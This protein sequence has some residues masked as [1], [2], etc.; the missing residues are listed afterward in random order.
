MTCLLNTYAQIS[1]LESLL[2]QLEIE[3]LTPLKSDNPSKNS[4]NTNHESDVRK[5]EMFGRDRKE[6]WFDLCQ[7]SISPDGSLIAIA[8]KQKVVICK[9]K[10][11][12]NNQIK[13]IAS[14]QIIF[15]EPQK[16]GLSN[17]IIY[18]I[19]QILI[20]YPCIFLK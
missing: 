19:V 6:S 8:S 2:E 12:L 10:W 1:N 13:F 14:S 5:P 4:E 16:C 17:K 20:I 11:D 7:L 3:E 15:E 18:L 9:R